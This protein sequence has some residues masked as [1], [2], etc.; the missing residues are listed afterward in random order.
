MLRR[1]LL[2]IRAVRAILGQH[3]AEPAVSCSWQCQ[4]QRPVVARAASLASSRFGPIQVLHN[5]VT[6]S[7]KRLAQG[8]PPNITAAQLVQVLFEVGAADVRRE[9][10]G[11][12]FS[13]LL[14]HGFYRLSHWQK[15]NS[16]GPAP[17]PAVGL[18]E[19]KRWATLL[20]LERLKQQERGEEAEQKRLK[21]TDALSRRRGVGGPDRAVAP[22][23]GAVWCRC[24]PGAS[25]T[26]SCA[27]RL[28]EQ[29]G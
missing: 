17:V 11:E 16:Y 24:P 2:G 23:C 20:F 26:R 1:G 9:D 3:A 19:C 15:R 21:V 7:F 18:D 27:M 10:V 25:G 22:A 6:T 13:K 4:Q 14:V 12:V 5:D 29:Q 28:L 8:S